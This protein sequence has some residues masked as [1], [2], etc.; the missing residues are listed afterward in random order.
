MAGPGVDVVMMKSD[1]LRLPGGDS[2]RDGGA[3][4]AAIRRSLEP[5]AEA[6]RGQRPGSRAAHAPST[7]SFLSTGTGLPTAAI[8]GPA[9]RAPLARGPFSEPR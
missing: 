4:P 8:V 6:P 2:P 9:R 5:A 7:S 1:P 3:R